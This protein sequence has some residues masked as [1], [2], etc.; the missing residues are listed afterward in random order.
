MTQSRVK[1]ILDSMTHCTE[2]AYEYIIAVTPNR[3]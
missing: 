3:L 1:G 2:E